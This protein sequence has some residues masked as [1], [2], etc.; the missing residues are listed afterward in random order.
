[1][2]DGRSFTNY[3]SSG[4]V[5]SEIQDRIGINKGMQPYRD[6]LQMNA[7]SLLEEEQM[8]AQAKVFTSNIWANTY[9]PPPPQN[10]LVA[11]KRRGMDIR[12]TQMHGGIGLGKVYENTRNFPM[13]TPYSDCLEREFDDP[14]WGISPETL[15]LTKRPA[16]SQGGGVWG[17]LDD[18]ERV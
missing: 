17:W 9:A 4:V 8:N 3:K 11:D 6:Y 15:V 1:M 5:A 13:Q 16:A 2:S 12:T 18:K 14:R 7:T 10:T